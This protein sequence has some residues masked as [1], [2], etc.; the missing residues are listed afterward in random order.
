MLTCFIFVILAI[1]AIK[2]TLFYCLSLLGPAPLSAL[3]SLS[4]LHPQSQ[5]M[6]GAW[7]REVTV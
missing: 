3:T 4:R 7:L 5:L 1:A 2:F 6:L